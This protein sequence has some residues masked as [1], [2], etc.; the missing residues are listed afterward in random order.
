MIQGFGT[1]VW[2]DKRSYT[3]NWLMDEMSGEGVFNW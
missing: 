1:Y 3:G 2:K